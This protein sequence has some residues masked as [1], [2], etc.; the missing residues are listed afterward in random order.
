MLHESRQVEIAEQVT[1]GGIYGF[2][3]LPSLG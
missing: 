2:G 3:D 1:L